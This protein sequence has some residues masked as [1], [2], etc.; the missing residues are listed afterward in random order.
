MQYSYWNINLFVAFIYFS[1]FNYESQVKKV[2]S[3]KMGSNSWT[4]NSHKKLLSTKNNQTHMV[5]CF[6]HD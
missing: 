5:R 1:N 4:D 2:I 3:I 6:Y